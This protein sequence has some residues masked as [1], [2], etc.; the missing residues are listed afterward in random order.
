MNPLR[1]TAAAGGLLLAAAGP[2]GAQVYKGVDENGN[3]VYSSSPFA[4]GDPEQARPIRIDPGPTDADRAAAE[5]RAQALRPRGSAGLPGPN[6]PPN[7]PQPPEAAAPTQ[8]RPPI[9]W[10]ADEAVRRAGSASRVQRGAG[11]FSGEGRVG[12]SRSSERSSR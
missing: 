11:G 9:D 7:A 4:T 1:L 2:L 10:Q 12:A 3:V 8:Q 6:E 5:R